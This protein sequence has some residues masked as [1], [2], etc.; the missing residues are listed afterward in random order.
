MAEARKVL[1][2]PL[3]AQYEKY[4]KW[5]LTTPR[6]DMDELASKRLAIGR[7]EDCIERIAPFVERG[8]DYVVLRIQL[9]GMRQRDALA[10]IR[11]FGKKV[12][13]YFRGISRR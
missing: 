4:S 8:A 9:E 11:L 1:Q 5:G 7:P 10:S 13:P 6:L 2:K 12:F 3:F